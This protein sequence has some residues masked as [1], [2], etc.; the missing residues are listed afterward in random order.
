MSSSIID[1]EG[2]L[3]Q[4]KILEP[5]INLEPEIEKYLRENEKVLS[6][7]VSY[8]KVPLE[9]KL[10]DEIKLFYNGILQTHLTYQPD[11]FRYYVNHVPNPKIAHEDII[12]QMYLFNGVLALFGIEDKVVVQRYSTE[13]EAKI[14]AYLSTQKT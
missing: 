3:S 8:L 7:L 6:E 1:I 13:L 9:Q 11:Y 4:L 14:S 12:T 10:P 5:N 2:T